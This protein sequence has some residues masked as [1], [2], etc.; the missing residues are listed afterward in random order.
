MKMMMHDNVKQRKDID[1]I[2]KNLGGHSLGGQ[3]SV[4]TEQAYGSLYQSGSSLQGYSAPAA[5]G[6]GTSSVLGILGFSSTS[7]EHSHEEAPWN[8]DSN[9]R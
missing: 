6:D 9:T 3:R 8:G 5:Q 2:L 7:P 1:Q 4:S